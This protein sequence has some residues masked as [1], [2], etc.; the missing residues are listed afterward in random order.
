MLLGKRILAVVPAR[1]GSKG[2]RDK[3]ARL[4][5]GKT[6][7]QRAAEVLSVLDWV[8][9][10]V[11]STDSRAYAEMAQKHGLDAPFLRPKHLSADGSGAIETVEHALVECEKITGYAFDI[12]LIIE[13]SCPLRQPSDI[14][15]CAR[16]LIKGSYDSVLTVSPLDLKFHPRKILSTT[17]DRI[18]PYVTANNPVVNRQELDSGLVFR[19]GCAYALTR[20]CL[21]DWR[22]IVPSN[23]GYVITDHPVIN[24]DAEIELD[25]ANF[26][27]DRF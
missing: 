14:E 1:S 16:H 12:I 6:M 25:I 21:C 8:D 3:N 17:Q 10:K 2:V 11:I 22:V 5:G 13:P 23:C 7:I 18:Q 20:N 4:I 24:I 27:N 9:F 19:N 26:L 15:S